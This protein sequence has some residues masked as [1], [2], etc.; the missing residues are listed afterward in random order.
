MVTSTAQG[1]LGFRSVLFRIL[2]TKL[3]VLETKH[4]CLREICMTAWHHWKIEKTQ[5]SCSLKKNWTFLKI[6]GI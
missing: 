5:F 2:M 4:H 6:R 3:L 1:N